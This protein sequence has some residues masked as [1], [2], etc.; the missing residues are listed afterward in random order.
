MEELRDYLRDKNRGKRPMNV[1]QELYRDFKY[2]Y[3]IDSPEDTNLI[4]SP[5]AIAR[6]KDIDAFRKGGKNIQGFK[7]DDVR[8]YARQADRN[9][10]AQKVRQAHNA[11]FA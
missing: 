5:E 8:E 7:E 4:M 9:A 10:E 6:R 3:G 2:K 1:D 11:R